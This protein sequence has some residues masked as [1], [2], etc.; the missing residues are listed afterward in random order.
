MEEIIK[1]YLEERAKTDMSVAFNLKKEN[2]N[3]KDCCKYIQ[4]QALKK[5]KGT[6]R[7]K[8]CMIDNDVV[9]GWAVHYY[10]EDSIDVNAPKKSTQSKSKPAEEPAKVVTMTNTTETTKTADKPQKKVAKVVQIDLFGDLFGE[11]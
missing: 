11:E 10:D 7:E 6:A 3:I 4:Q 8:A 5:A 1:A 9:Y 2:K